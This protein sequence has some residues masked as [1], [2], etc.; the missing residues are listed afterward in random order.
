MIIRLKEFYS[1]NKKVILIGLWTILVASLSFG[2]GY[3]TNRE[4]NR[5]PIVIERC[6][7]S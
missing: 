6:S 1:E 5:A 7:G 4:F 2:L 3:L